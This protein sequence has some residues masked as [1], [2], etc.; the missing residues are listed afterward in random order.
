M[1]VLTRFSVTLGHERTGALH[2]N[3]AA[4]RPTSR[5]ES[6]LACAME[7]KAVRI[8]LK[9]GSQSR[10]HQWAETIE[11]RKDEALA[12]LRDE[13]VVLEAYFLDPRE[14]GAYLI[15]IISAHDLAHAEAAGRVSTHELDAYHKAFQRDTWLEVTP[16][17]PIVQL[18]RCSDGS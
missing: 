15:A 12:T 1:A 10:V 9:S 3:G 2:A 8:K 5:P 11:R 16:L 14:D 18:H 4:S 17:E 6:M 7:T 13:G